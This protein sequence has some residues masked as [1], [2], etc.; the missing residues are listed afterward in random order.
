MHTSVFMLAIFPSLKTH[1]CASS[2]SLMVGSL[3][4]LNYPTNLIGVLEIVSQS[5]WQSDCLTTSLRASVSVSLPFHPNLTLPGISATAVA[6]SSHKCA[7]TTTGGLIC[8]GSNFD[9]QLGIGSSSPQYTRSPQTVSLG[10]GAFSE[11][12]MCCNLNVAKHT[13]QGL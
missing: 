3:T 13:Q 9:G 2:T 7:I 6:V 10:P 11:I 8:W 1:T 5:V 4:C 12:K